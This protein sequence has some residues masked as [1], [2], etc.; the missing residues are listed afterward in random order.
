MGVKKKTELSPFEQELKQGASKVQ[1]YKTIAEANIISL[2]WK[3]TDLMYSYSNVKREDISNN[4]WK[5]YW[6]VAHD[7]V[8]KE[9]KV[10]DEITVNFYLE[11]HPKLQQKFEEYGGYDN[12]VD[13]GVY[14]DEKNIEG[15]VHELQKWNVV[16]EMLRN[17]FPVA[18]RISEFVDMEIEQIYDEY[19]VMLNHIFAS[20]EGN[21][22]SY[23]LGDGIYNLIDKLDEGEAIGMPFEGLPLYNR[24]TGGVYLGGIHLIGGLSNVGKSSFIR[25][26]LIPSCIKHNEPLVIFL[27]EDGLSKYQ[28]EMIVWVANNIFKTPLAKYTVRD[29]NYSS[30]TRALMT[31]C[32]DW[33]VEQDSKGLIKIVPLQKY[34]TSTVIKHINKYAHLGFKTFVIDTFKADH[35]ATSDNQWFLMQQSMVAIADII[36]PEAKNLAIVV[37]FQ[38]DKASAKQRH[39]TQSNI[40][41][42]KNIVDVASTCTMIRNVLDDEYDGE[43]RSLQVFRLEGVAGKTKIPSKLLKDKKYQVLFVVKSREGSTDFQIVTE[44]N[45]STNTVKEI[46]ITTVPT[47]W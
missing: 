29:G 32:A 44:T 34:K 26:T 35:D 7:I 4:M 28:R 47:D 27:N 33:I 41:T 3:N 42:A 22:K 37:T 31:K 36:K 30:D 16:L 6:Q 18:S 8:I 39:Y 12:I 21:A 46:G 40:S 17:K 5:V 25:N 43:K 2:F 19:T 38:L 15:Y 24:E 45:L 11:K 23:N 10:L 14:V 13:V 20:A 9:R 1:E